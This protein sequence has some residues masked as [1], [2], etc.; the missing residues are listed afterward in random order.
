MSFYKHPLDDIHVGDYVEV[1]FNGGYVGEPDYMYTIKG[2]VRIHDGVK[3]VGRNGLGEGK[4]LVHQQRPM[5]T[6]FGSHIRYPNGAE[7]VKVDGE[8][9]RSDAGGWRL[10]REM[11][12]NWVLIRDAEV[13]A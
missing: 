3:S 11:P 9:W 10:N 6:A 8:H 1:E 2:P 7:W 12:R 5:P 13:K 4:I